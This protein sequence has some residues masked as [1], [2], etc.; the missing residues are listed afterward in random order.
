MN[1]PS[2]PAAAPRAERHHPLIRSYV[3]RID[4]PPGVVFPLLCPVR[5]GDWLEGWA[6]DCEVIWSSS[7]VAE[8]GCVFRTSEIGRP[9]TVWIVTEYDPGRGTVAFAR[10]TPGLEATTLRIQVT[11]AADGGSLV[12]IG[13]VVVPTTTAGQGEA[14][15]RYEPSAFVASIVWWERSMNHYV[16]TGR[17]LRR[18]ESEPA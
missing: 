2:K 10:V 7:G 5:E 4:A 1:T 17:Q 14:A 12:D 16:R 6:E 11:P 3:Q 9:D 15:R 18:S 13:Y 8:L